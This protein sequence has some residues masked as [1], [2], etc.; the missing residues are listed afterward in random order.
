MMPRDTQYTVFDDQLGGF[1]IRIGARTKSFIVMYGP[2]RRLK[3]LGRYP[4]ISLKTAREKAFELLGSQSQYSPKPASLSYSEAVER[5]LEESR[6]KHK[7][8]TTNDYARHLS[9]YSFGKKVSEITRSDIMT[10]LGYLANQPVTQN[11]TFDTVSNFF[12][13]CLR[14]DFI[15]RHPLQGE[16]KSS[17]KKHR[18]RVLTEEE[19]KQVYKRA[20]ET[21]FPYGPFV[22]LLILTGQRRSE[23]LFLTW[24][25][26][27]EELQFIDTKNGT[28]HSIPVMPMVREIIDTLPKKHFLFQY[29][30][31]VPFGAFNKH[32][33]AFDKPLDIAPYRLHDLRR[34]FSSTMAMLGTP[35]HVTERILNH[36]SG[37]ISGIQAVY[38]RYTF[39]KE[40]KEALETYE[41]YISKLINA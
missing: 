3:T 18:E 31:P 39:D 21:P 23:I 19:L 12:N 37:T 17:P 35:L 25:N 28:D 22:R 34:T 10:R 13:W 41:A 29:M 15:Q 4:S 33:I 32:K 14:N 40:I 24:E 20:V 6:A 2:T 11:H 5:F 26:V 7:P 9:F 8:Q 36:K 1:G 30:K 38:N 27:G 16:K